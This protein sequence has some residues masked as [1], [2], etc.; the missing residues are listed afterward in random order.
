MNI[1]ADDDLLRGT[2]QVRHVSNKDVLQQKN[3]ALVITSHKGDSS[4]LTM[5]LWEG[6]PPLEVWEVQAVTPTS[7]KSPRLNGYGYVVQ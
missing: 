7:P 5:S 3:E 6:G 1:L 2:A 4:M